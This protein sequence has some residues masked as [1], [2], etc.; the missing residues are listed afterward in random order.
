MEKVEA[1]KSQN[2]RIYADARDCKNADK[3]FAINKAVT[4]LKIVLGDQQIHVLF[5]NIILKRKEVL[6]ILTELYRWIGD[7]E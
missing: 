6:A 5:K 7:D 2:G 4:E 1:Y 3:E